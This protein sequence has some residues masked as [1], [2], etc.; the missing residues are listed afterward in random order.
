MVYLGELFLRID[1]LF[2]FL[3]ICLCVCLG[4]IL[5]FRWVWNLLVLVFLLFLVMFSFCWMIFNCF[6]RK[7]LCWCLL[8][9][10]LILVDSFFCRCVIFIFLCSSGKIFFICL[11]IGMVFSIFCSLLLGV[12]VRVVVKLVSGDGL[13]GLKWFRQFFSFLLYSGLS[14]SSFLI[15]LIRVM[16]QVF[17]LL[18]GLIGVFGQFIFI[19]NGG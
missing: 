2:S 13:L 10:W 19:M 5:F 9:L 11:R 16:L 6:L 1:S 17:I 14:G 7:N 3:L 18:L 8:I 15:V 12:V 4:S